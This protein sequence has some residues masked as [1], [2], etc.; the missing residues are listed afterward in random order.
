MVKSSSKQ[1]LYGKVSSKKDG[2]SLE[3][4]AV[5][6]VDG[7]LLKMKGIKPAITDKQ[8]RFSL[9]VES[10]KKESEEPKGYLQ[11]L[12]KDGAPIFVSDSE[13]FSKGGGLDQIELVVPDEAIQ[14]ASY[15]FS[16]FQFKSLVGINPNYFG[17]FEKLKLPLKV[18]VIQPKKGDTKYEELECIGLYPETDELEA[19][20]KVKL[21]YGYGGE[22]CGSG[23]K[24][25]VAFYVDYGSGFEPVG[26]AV[27]VSAHNLGAAR[28]GP[29]CYAVKQVV[30]FEKKSCKTPYLVKLRAILSWNTPPMGP[31]YIPTWGN[32]KEAWVQINPSKKAWEILTGDFKEL[33]LVKSY[34]D[35]QHLK[36]EL[37]EKMK[38]S[39]DYNK[40]GLDEDRIDFK[41]NILKNPNYYAGMAD[42]N[43]IQN[44]YD[45]IHM[46]P[47]EILEKFKPKLID[48]KWLFPIK[49]L[50]Y[51]TSFEELS[52]VGLFPEQNT[53]EAVVAVKRQNGYK[54]DLCSLG[55]E[56]YVAFY[57]DWGDGLGY[58]HEGT[59]FFKVHDIPRNV[60]PLMYAVNLRVDDM[61]RKLKSCKVENIIKVRAILS[62]EVAPTGPNYRPAWGNVKEC[63]VQVRTYDGA[64]NQCEIQHVN[65][66]LVEDINTDGYAR[67]YINSTTLS[68]NLFDRPF[69]NIIA[70]W[71]HINVPTSKYFR[72]LFR[73]ESESSWTVVEDGRR[74]KQGLFTIG[75]RLPDENGWFRIDEYNY[76]LGNYSDTP[77][78]NW[79]SGSRTGK[80]RLRL[81]CADASKT[82][83]QSCE[84]S[85]FLD[86][87]NPEHYG[88][89]D[90]PIP[91]LGL[92]VKN[93]S[94]EVK[95][96]GKYK[97]AEKVLV[98]GNFKD[99]HFNEFSLEIFGGNL[100]SA[101]KKITPAVNRYDEGG[102]LDTNGIVG[103]S[104]PGKGKL[105]MTI[106]NMASAPINSNVDCA[107]GIRMVT[108]DRAILGSFS[109]YVFR[110]TS[111]SKA[112]YVTF[113]WAP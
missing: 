88:F 2:S 61:D 27:S 23:S 103:A 36:E 96:C 15:D 11:V 17:A 95:E 59:R 91:Q 101:G 74:Y 4:L 3:G 89:T 112:S 50:K 5:E 57:V 82:P 100:P 39:L 85:V 31:N 52:C 58:R 76:D 48:P 24:E 81:E 68:P 99:D 9:A 104:D 105:L 87:Q 102:K 8:G 32:V 113:N 65:K 98:Y 79:A 18:P 63:R 14:A 56:E 54:G 80:Y 16:R 10:S 20:F 77:L 42:E 47:P 93:S 1:M 67:K 46:L 22:L 51:N 75:L 55:S 94:G 83:I 84:V 40:K 34:S 86:N 108:S 33:S 71:G 73:K 78:A 62:W 44:A 97:G 106:D 37:I 13:I 19:V 43:E 109:G 41:E 53:L 69:G 110:S 70:I 66:V 29:L 35:L 26:P 72:M 38:A 107:Y 7:N 90:S 49:P 25:F 92:T 60:N 12:N 30:D 64:N 28:K 111:H 45:Q 6:L 21:P